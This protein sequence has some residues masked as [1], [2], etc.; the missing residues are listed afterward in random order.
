MHIDF[1]PPDISQREIDEVT[2]VLRSGWITTG[3]KAKELE[4]LV[5]DA[6]GTKRAVCLNSATAALSTTLRVLGI[7]QGDEVITTPYTYTA[8]ASVIRHVSATPV[9]VDTSPD[10][11]HIDCEKVR[12]AITPRTKA[13]IAVDVAG[14]MADY[15][16]LIAISQEKSGLFLP[17]SGL[18]RT[19]G[20]LCVIA[21]AAHSLGAWRDGKLSGAAADFSSFS[22]HAV[23]NLTTAEGGAATWNPIPGVDDEE[24]YRLYMLF[25]LHGQSKDAYEKT[26][27]GNW[28]YDIVALAFKCNLPD[29]LAALGVAQFARYGEMLARRRELAVLYDA[30]LDD[31]RFILP[32]HHTPCSRSSVHLYPLR[33]RGRDEAYRNHVIRRMA[34]EGIATNVHYKPLP[35]F[36]AYKRLGFRIEDYPNAYA[37]YQNE[38]TLPLH[39]LLTD[40]EV[41]YVADALKR[42]AD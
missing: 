15:G 9:L 31:R 37:Q 42:I 24:L 2:A 19:M 40:G 5:A 36:T 35:L 12:S 13:I 34:E 26:R 7:G 41:G 39:S 11:F 27:L 38:L 30:Y 14:M 33:L 25:S 20:R 29:V 28:E 22:F 6:C 10:S 8:S 16:R 18:Q 32:V 23:K 3:A 4:R 21:D 1:S 17:K